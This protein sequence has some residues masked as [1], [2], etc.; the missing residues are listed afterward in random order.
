[1]VTNLARAPAAHSPVDS[2]CMPYFQDERAVYGH[3]G[4]LLR[5]AAADEALGARLRAAD[6]VVQYDVRRPNARITAN[7]REGGDLRVDLGATELR[8]DVVL[9]MDGDTAHAYWQG[10]VNLSVALAKGQIKAF[11]PVAAILRLVPLSQ[12]LFPRY[13]DLVEGGDLPSLDAS[14]GPTTVDANGQAPAPEG[15]AEASPPESETSAPEA[16]AS[17]SAA[18]ESSAGEAAAEPAA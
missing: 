18:G 12:A 1:M 13:R 3:I 6:A 14:V 15:E 16:E 11:G 8:P 5:A 9:T 2:P 4:Y 7:L 10:Q 17:A